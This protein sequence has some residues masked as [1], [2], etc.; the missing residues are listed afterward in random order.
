MRMYPGLS[1]VTLGVT[2]VGQSSQFYERLGW[3]RSKGASN[4]S[5]SFFG[6]NNIVLALFARQDLA[7]D[8]G[9]GSPPSQGVADGFSGITLAQNYGSSG[10]VD[11]AFDSAIAAGG[12]SLVE[13]RRADWGGYH[14]VFSDPDG[15]IWELACNPFLELSADGTLSLP[16]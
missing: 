8:S 16:P 15:H 9:F 4:P 6:L 5:I 3:R 13:P 12:K 10:A 14:G 2:D 7:R 1:I 11:L